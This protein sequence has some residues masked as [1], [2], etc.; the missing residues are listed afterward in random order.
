MFMGAAFFCLY[1]VVPYSIRR[2][3]YRISSR[4]RDRTRRDFDRLRERFSSAVLRLRRRSRCSQHSL[5]QVIFSSEDFTIDLAYHLEPDEACRLWAASSALRNSPGAA[6][7]RTYVYVFGG[8]GTD[9]TN[10]ERLDLTTGTWT[11]LEPMPCGR[12]LATGIVS[13]GCFYVCGGTIDGSTAVR[14]VDYFSPRIGSWNQTVPM[15]YPRLWAAGAGLGGCLF[16]FGGCADVA[17]LTCALSNGE[18]FDPETGEWDMTASM[19]FPRCG[20]TCASIVGR[21]YVCGGIDGTEA[22]DSVERF[23]AEVRDWMMMPH[24]SCGRG[25]PC[26]AVVEPRLYIF[27]GTSSSSALDSSSQPISKFGALDSVECFTPELSWDRLQ[28]MTVPRFGACSAAIAGHI[29][30]F[31]GQSKQYVRRSVE[32]FSICSLHAGG[33]SFCRCC[34]VLDTYAARDPGIWNQGPRMLES[35][36]FAVGGV[37]G[38]F[39]M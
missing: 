23:D 21:L 37:L 13:N 15:H 11:Q 4:G 19:H 36:V 34:N 5:G 39:T 8:C 16:V 38:S 35:R 33:S 20:A 31:G 9:S 29:Y 28:S 3:R 1:E 26:S 27:G 2:L 6:K 14:D 30:V 17:S 18:C 22:L 32:A 25:W 12:S 24:M 7:F 10:T